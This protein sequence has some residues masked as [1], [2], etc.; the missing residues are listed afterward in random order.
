MD[1]YQFFD[2]SEIFCD[3]H[4]FYT[5]KADSLESALALFTLSLVDHPLLKLRCLILAYVDTLWHFHVKR[6]Q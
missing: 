5:K 1:L 2:E 6:N 3:E 4:E